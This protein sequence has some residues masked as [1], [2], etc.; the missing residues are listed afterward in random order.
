LP[1]MQEAHEEYPHQ[2]VGLGE[3]TNWFF[4]TLICTQLMQVQLLTSFLF[5]Y[6]FEFWDQAGWH[7]WCSYW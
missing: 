2:G 5:S 4:K 1:N 6:N 7:A 3:S